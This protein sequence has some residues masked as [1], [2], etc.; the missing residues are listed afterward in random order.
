VT[1]PE[2]SDPFE[3]DSGLSAEQHFV[4]L[5]F[6]PEMKKTFRFNVPISGRV[7]RLFLL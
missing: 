4:T 2:A 1:Q 6:G 3:L 7:R 5:N